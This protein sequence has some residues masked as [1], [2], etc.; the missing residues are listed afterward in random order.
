MYEV[1]VIQ[2]FIKLK[3]PLKV[4]GL[5]VTHSRHKEKERPLK[6]PL[7]IVVQDKYK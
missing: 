6:I 1:M 5:L 2:Q 4:R 3:N 7:Y